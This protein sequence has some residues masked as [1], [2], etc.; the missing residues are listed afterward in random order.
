MDKV[1]DVTLRMGSSMSIIGPSQSGK[2]VF[3][4]NL[5]R[6]REHM[7]DVEINRVVWISP[8]ADIPPGIIYLKS[9]D[10][11]TPEINDLLILDDVMTENDRKI[12]EMFIRGSHH[13]K[14]FTILVAQ[15]AF[16]AST[17]HR[18]RMINS[19]YLILFK[20]PRDG[21]QISVISRQIYNDDF[22][23]DVYDA[24]TKNRPHSYV[25]IDLKQR[26]PDEIR[27][28]TNIFP[29]EIPHFVYV[30]S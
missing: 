6:Y 4:N 22:L 3:C 26:T 7:F 20:N 30:K 5:I 14:I 24:V 18:T 17:H 19:N 23:K 16:Y 1:Y 8:I 13:H 2:S 15:N 12:T 11:Y 29:P 25:L 27:V 9:I 28:R 21:K 10:E